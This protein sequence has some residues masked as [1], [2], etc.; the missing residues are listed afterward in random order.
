MFPF[1]YLFF[2]ANLD[3]GKIFRPHFCWIA[4]MPLWSSPLKQH[5]PLQPFFIFWFHILPYI[6]FFF[7]WWFGKL[8]FS[9][10]LRF[11]TFPTLR[12]Y[13]NIFTQ[14]QQLIWNR[15]TAGPFYLV[16]AL[17]LKPGR[18]PSYV[19]LIC[20]THN[21]T[22]RSCWFAVVVVVDVVVVVVVVIIL[23]KQKCYDLLENCFAF[24]LRENE[25]EHIL[26]VVN[27]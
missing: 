10:F 27:V 22:P 6:K 15:F 11:S 14:K 20:V 23:I 9:F 1:I 16:I 8:F 2:A 19:C 3:R 26:S 12:K 18:L 17:P 21:T 7:N 13:W 5:W 24:A 4:G 25:E